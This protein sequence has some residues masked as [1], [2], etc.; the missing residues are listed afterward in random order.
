MWDAINRSSN[1]FKHA[2][3]DPHEGLDFN[4]DMNEVMLF[5]CVMLL[6]EFG[7]GDGLKFRT[8]VAWFTV[9]HPEF[10]KPEIP[11]EA[12]TQLRVYIEL[13]RTMGLN[14]SRDVGLSVVQNLLRNDESKVA[15]L[16]SPR[17]RST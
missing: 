8:Y 4:P 3:R 17:T 13:A 16:K 12:P 11:G 2:D 10:L 6:S 14:K 15:A 9:M 7:C 1:F 5:L